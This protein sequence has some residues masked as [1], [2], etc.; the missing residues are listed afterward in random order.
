GDEECGQGGPVGL[1][2][3]AYLLGTGGPAGTA[4]AALGPPFR[5]AAAVGW[6]SEWLIGG[7][8]PARARRGRISA[9]IVPP[10]RPAASHGGGD[11]SARPRPAEDPSEQL[12][13]AGDLVV[14]VQALHILVQRLPAQPQPG[15]RVLFPYRRLFLV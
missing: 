9:G 2:H 12:G 8:P 5:R 4:P 6:P 14:A 13:P 3:G 1:R 7:S 10:D 11:G 15:G